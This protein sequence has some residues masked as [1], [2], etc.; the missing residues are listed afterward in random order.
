[1]AKI[2]SLKEI[3]AL[4]DQE[5]KDFKF[6]G[7][8]SLILGVASTIVLSILPAFILMCVMCFMCKI[9]RRYWNTKEY[10]LGLMKQHRRKRR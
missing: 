8:I 9:D 10:M 4:A 5:H 7:C 6:F 3:R 1:M 2:I